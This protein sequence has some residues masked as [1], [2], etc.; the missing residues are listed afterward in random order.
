M[1]RAR[2]DQIQEGASCANMYE[3]ELFDDKPTQV[4]LQGA[5]YTPVAP[6][7]AITEKSPIEFDIKSSGSEYID[8]ND[9]RLFVS[10]TVKSETVIQ[11]AD[12]NKSGYGFANLPSPRSLATRH[13][14]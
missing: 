2:V 9:V 3:I 13:S 7:N 5:Y 4:E 6:I 14:C 11:E 10:F 8:L 1:K 12:K